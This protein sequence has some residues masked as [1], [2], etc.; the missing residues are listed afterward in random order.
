MTRVRG[1]C[2]GTDWLSSQHSSPLMERYMA[3]DGL[4][5]GLSARSAITVDR[6]RSVIEE[7]VV[8][9][10]SSPVDTYLAATASSAIVNTVMTARVLATPLS[11]RG[12][13][14]IGE[15]ARSMTRLFLEGVR[16]C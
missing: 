12:G 9:G 1:V 3:S 4:S 11:E 5:A 7:S 13:G 16:A 8:L 15:R 14:S 2:H 10:E 6:I